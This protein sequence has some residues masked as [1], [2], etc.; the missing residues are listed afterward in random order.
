MTFM[1]IA[2][3]SLIVGVIFWVLGT[4]EERIKELE[5]KQKGE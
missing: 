1:L 2:L 5:N 4:L 3:I